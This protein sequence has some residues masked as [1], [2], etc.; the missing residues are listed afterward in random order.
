MKHIVTKVVC[1]SVL[2]ALCVGL[3]AAD[4]FAN[5]SQIPNALLQPHTV[6][7]QAGPQALAQADEQQA[8]DAI[9]P[10]ETISNSIGMQLRLIK[11]G[12]FMMGSTA[13]HS[14]E[15]PIHKVT[16]TKPFYMGV[17]E[18]TQEQYEKVMGT[19][20]SHFQGP[21]RPVEQ[22]SWNDAQ[23]F[24]QK[25]S[26]QENRS[27]RL[28][29]EAEWEY[30]CRAGS[31]T[32][33]FWGRRFFS[34]Y[35]WSR[36]NSA[37]TTQDVGTRLPNAWRLYDMSGNVWEWCESRKGQYAPSAAEETDPKGPS[38]GRSRVLRGGSWYGVAENCRSAARDKNAPNSR[39]YTF[40]F[41]VV[42]DVN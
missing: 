8:N 7:K 39:H 6:A 12:S 16:L 18:V 9:P 41:R 25:L 31:T 11:S 5:A 22:V 36:Q 42:I 29:T 35:A 19:N 1:F 26:E 38:K 10:K 40:G 21:R 30:A 2:V 33:Y 14:D 17:Y 3:L 27:Y 28:P 4:T 32:E 15:M 20:P 34:R 37:E 23:A 13:G 24:C